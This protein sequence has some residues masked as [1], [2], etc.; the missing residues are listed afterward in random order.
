MS[1]EE[2][3]EYGQLYSGGGYLTFN[4]SPVIEKIWPLADR[5][6]AGQRSG[7]RVYRRRI[8][9]IEDWEEVGPQCSARH[10]GAA[11]TVEQADRIAQLRPPYPPQSADPAER[12][13]GR[14][15]WHTPSAEDWNRGNR[16]SDCRECGAE[17]TRRFCDPTW[18]TRLGG[19]RLTA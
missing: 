16:E 5:I 12:C 3:V 17:I 9:V 6:K 15:G 10:R 14:T 8:V 4:D 19:G 11:L 13:P 1:G 7:G 18:R 2:K